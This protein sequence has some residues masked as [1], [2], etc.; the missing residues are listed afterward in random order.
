M[1]KKEM[2]CF[3][4][5]EAKR[6]LDCAR[7][8]KWYALFL[9]IIES[10]M[11][12]E[13]YFGLQWKDIDFEQSCLSVVRVVVESKQ[14]GFYFSEPKTKKSRRKIPLSGSVIKALKH[15]RRVQLERKLKLGAVLQ[16]L[17]L[18]FASENRRRISRTVAVRISAGENSVAIE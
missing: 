8:S 9:L 17:D 11:R 2:K 13:E 7:Q 16:D 6:F 12:P 4:P 3:T 1:I 5:Q 14:G 18:V 15:H 10:G